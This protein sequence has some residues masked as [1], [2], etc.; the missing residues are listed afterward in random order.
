MIH[1]IKP[2]PVSYM[3]KRALLSP[4]RAQ[5]HLSPFPP[6]PC[7]RP[8]PLLLYSCCSIHP[9]PKASNVS[10]V[11]RE[12]SEGK[13]WLQRCFG[14]RPKHLPHQLQFMLCHPGRKLQRWQRVCEGW[15]WLWKQKPL[16]CWWMQEDL[17][18]W[19][20]W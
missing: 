16:Q 8:A 4:W 5:V 7:S 11:H 20:G 2:I 18:G 14:H 6:T 13:K 3:H 1:L 12:D 17:C 19:K 15:W 9:N 10:P